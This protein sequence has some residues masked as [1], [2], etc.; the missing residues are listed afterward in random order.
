MAFISLLTAL[1][2]A[3][4]VA[5]QDIR[6]AEK[7]PAFILAG[8]STTAINGGWG[9]GFLSTLIGDSTGINIGKSG[10]TT[11][12][13]VNGGYWENVTD[14]LTEWVEDY[15]VF[16]TISVRSCRIKSGESILT[17]QLLVRS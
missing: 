2:W 11:I 6:R 3:T 7:P 12:S 14:H 10:A 15:E 13:F 8:D 4:G 5:S 9:D 17:D 16:V 1:A